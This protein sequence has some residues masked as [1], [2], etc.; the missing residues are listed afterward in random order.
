MKKKI[1]NAVL[2]FLVLYVMVLQV[3]LGQGIETFFP[4]YRRAET[5]IY[6]VIYISTPTNGT[7]HFELSCNTS[8]MKNII[9]CELLL[10]SFPHHS[11]TRTVVRCIAKLLL[12]PLLLPLMLRP[13]QGFSSSQLC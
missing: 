12:L 7:D 5:K 10:P 13:P 6:F 1:N 3:F 8:S 11:V 2:F 4:L 9:M